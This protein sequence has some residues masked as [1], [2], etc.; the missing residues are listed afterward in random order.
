MAAGMK[1]KAWGGAPKRRD[2]L[3]KATVAPINERNIINQ[4]SWDRWLEKQGKGGYVS[5]IDMAYTGYGGA[6][7]PTVVQPK[8][9][10][11]GFDTA[12]ADYNQAMKDMREDAADYVS[13]WSNKMAPAP[14]RTGQARAAPE[15]RLVV[16]GPP[17]ADEDALYGRPQQF[18]GISSIV[19]LK[20][21]RRA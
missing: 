7:K 3:S 19:N 4:G 9:D 1:P 2:Y 14:G 10:Q 20:K 16:A 15:G 13:E 8:L 5:S 17:P 18:P 12:T 6:G 11:A 21:K